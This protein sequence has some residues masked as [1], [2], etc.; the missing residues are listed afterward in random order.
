MRAAQG[1]EVPTVALVGEHGD[2]SLPGEF[3]P[4]TNTLRITLPGL[5]PMDFRRV[6]LWAGQSY[7]IACMAKLTQRQVTE[8]P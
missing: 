4:G 8:G 6:D 2:V 7:V 5:D 3:R 1:G